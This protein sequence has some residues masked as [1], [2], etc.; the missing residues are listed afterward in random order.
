VLRAFRARGIA[1]QRLG[2]SPAPWQEIL[3]D[4]RTSAP[5]ATL[6]PVRD[7]DDGAAT[8]PQGSSRVTVQF[9]DNATTLAPIQGAES[10]AMEIY[11]RFSNGVWAKRPGDDFDGSGVGNAT[12]QNSFNTYTP[13]AGAVAVC[14]VAGAASGFY[15]VVSCEV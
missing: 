2:Y 15:C 7:Q 4:I 13:P 11:W 3:T 9:I 8:I 1:P 14:P 12:A 10:E 5:A 6:D